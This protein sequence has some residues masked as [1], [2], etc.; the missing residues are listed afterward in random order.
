MLICRCN[1]LIKPN[2]VATIAQTTTTFSR[3]NRKLSF[4]TPKKMTVAIEESTYSN[5]SVT[6]Q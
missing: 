2:C 6:W 3:G 4:A 1:I 5:Q